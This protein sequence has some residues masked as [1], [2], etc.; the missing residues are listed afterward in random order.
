MDVTQLLTDLA[1]DLVEFNKYDTASGSYLYRQAWRA[2]QRVDNKYQWRHHIASTT[3]A[4]TQDTDGPYSLPSDFKGML[5]EERLSPLY[6][7]D[8]QSVP[9]I[10]DGDYQVMYNVYWKRAEN[11]L[12]F[13]CYVPAGNY[14]FYYRKRFDALTDLS[15]WPQDLEMSVAAWAKYYVLNNSKDTYEQALN[16]FKLAEEET[17]QAWNTQRKGDSLQETRQPRDING[18]EVGLSDDSEGHW[19]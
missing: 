4:V 5:R 1:N 18:D 17:R 7:Y 9:I 15:A 13:D 3:I 6:T 12:Y 14:T 2:A 8:K 11:K 10:P 19:W 16:F